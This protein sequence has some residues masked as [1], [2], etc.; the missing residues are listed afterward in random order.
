[1][2]GLLVAVTALLTGLLSALLLLARLLIRTAVLLTALVALLVLLVLA[3]LVLLAHIH[4]LT[5]GLVVR[6]NNPFGAS[7]REPTLI[8]RCG[9]VCH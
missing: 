9:A 8:R 4:F 3:A 6:I 5:S 7:F 2:T 1:L